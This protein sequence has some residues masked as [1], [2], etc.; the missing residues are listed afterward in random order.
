MNPQPTNGGNNLFSD[1]HC[2][3]LDQ[4]EIDARDDVILFQTP[5]LTEELV[6]T[7]PINGYLQVSSD[8]IDTDIMVLLSHVHPVPF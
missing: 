8:A 5:V 7:G 2:G 1:T 6:L 3:P 4:V